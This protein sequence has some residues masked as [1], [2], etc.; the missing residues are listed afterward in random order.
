MKTT[1]PAMT[2]KAAKILGK[3]TAKTVSATGTI[4]DKTVNTIKVTP[5]KTGEVTKNIVGAIAEGYREVRPADETEE[6]TTS[7]DTTPE[8]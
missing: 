8:A 7:D 6:T 4:T 2:T 5:S 1:K 3:I